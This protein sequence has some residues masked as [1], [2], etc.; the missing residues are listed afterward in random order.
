[1][2]QNSNVTDN[3]VNGENT[4]NMLGNLHKY[5]RI[6][7]TLVMFSNYFGNKTKIDNNERLITGVSG[8]VY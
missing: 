5:F 6:A 7:Y 1:M 3:Y 2:L 8:A 4:L